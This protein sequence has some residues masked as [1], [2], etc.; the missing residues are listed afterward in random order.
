MEDL[1]LTE[2]FVCLIVLLATFFAIGFYPL[3]LQWQD[4]RR[5]YKE[6]CKK[7]KKRKRRKK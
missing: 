5:E 6:E 7:Q 3:L 2:F 4:R 1:T